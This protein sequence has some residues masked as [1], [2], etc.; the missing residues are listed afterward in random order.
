MRLFHADRD[1]E[2]RY[3]LHPRGAVV[4]VTIVSLVEVIKQNE[5]SLI[6]NRYALR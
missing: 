3:N 5:E 1:I 4:G 6:F 2:K